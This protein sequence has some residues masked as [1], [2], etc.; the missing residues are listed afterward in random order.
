MI[1]GFLSW[2]YRR[3][4]SWFGQNMSYY[5]VLQYWSLITTV[6]LFGIAT[7]MPSWHSDN[8]AYDPINVARP[9]LKYLIVDGLARL[10]TILLL[11]V[12]VGIVGSLFLQTRVPD[13]GFSASPSAEYPP[14]LDQRTVWLVFWFGPLPGIALWVAL[15]DLIA[16]WL[17]S[18][19]WRLI[20][21][22]AVTLADAA[23]RMGLP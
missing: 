6:L 17:Q 4:G 2:V 19:I 3:G 1:I 9:A 23:N 13:I 10:A 16:T 21:L 11:V 22:G 8:R 20:T 18:S 14:T 5:A 15:S 7:T 12:L